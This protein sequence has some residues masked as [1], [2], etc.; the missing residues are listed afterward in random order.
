MRTSSNVRPRCLVSGKT[1]FTV[2]SPPAL[3]SVLGVAS[4]DKGEDERE[5]EGEATSSGARQTGLLPADEGGPTV[6]AAAMLELF[7]GSAFAGA[8]AAAGG[9]L[10]VLGTGTHSVLGQEREQHTLLRW[11]APVVNPR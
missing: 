11:N 3:F 4:T 7:G 10:L 2:A 5:D 9:A 6:A 8:G 1:R